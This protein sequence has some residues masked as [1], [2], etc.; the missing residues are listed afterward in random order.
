[1]SSLAPGSIGLDLG[2]G[3]G[4]YLPL[5]TERPSSVRTIGVD[6][7]FN[8]LEIARTAGNDGSEVVQGDVLDS[9]WRA[10]LF[11]GHSSFKYASIS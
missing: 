7:S 6:R 1:M 8:L 9:P 10:G 3:N 2:C 11:V 4:K 5:P